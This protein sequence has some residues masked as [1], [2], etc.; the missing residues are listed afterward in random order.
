VPNLERYRVVKEQFGFS[1]IWFCHLGEVPS[2]E[3]EVE[4]IGA[5][6]REASRRRIE[7]VAAHSSLIVTLPEYWKPLGCHQQRFQLERAIVEA[8][9]QLC[10]VRYR[11]AESWRADEALYREGWRARLKSPA[12]MLLAGRVSVGTIHVKGHGL[13]RMNNMER[14]LAM[15]PEHY[16]TRQETASLMVRFAHEHCNAEVERRRKAEALLE[17]YR[18]PETGILIAGFDE[19]ATRG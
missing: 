1:R 8:G 18:D 12:S 11:E 7:E 10:F 17:S 6:V 5:L 19:E 14:A 9:A 3:Q 2:T 15:L 13:S 4:D 16:L